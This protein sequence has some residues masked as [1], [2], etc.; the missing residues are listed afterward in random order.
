MNNISGIIDGVK[1]TTESKIFISHYHQIIVCNRK[2]LC[3]IIIE[4]KVLFVI[5][6][7]GSCIV[8]DNQCHQTVKKSNHVISILK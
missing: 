1:K 7:L 5:L 8:S 3:S 2:I 6:D 4:R